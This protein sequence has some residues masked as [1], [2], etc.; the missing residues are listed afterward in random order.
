MKMFVS[1][2]ILVLLNTLQ[3]AGSIVLGWLL[4]IF[5]DLILSNSLFIQ[6][7]VLFIKQN[8]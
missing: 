3:M 7:P 8:M 4:L 5:N 1:V 6:K 2:E